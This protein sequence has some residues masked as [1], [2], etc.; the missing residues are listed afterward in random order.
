MGD[1][2][3][4][5]IRPNLSKTAGD[6]RSH[7][8][9][10]DTPIFSDTLQEVTARRALVASADLM[11]V[12][13]LVVEAQR[14]LSASSEPLARARLHHALGALLAARFD[15]WDEALIH[16][17]LAHELQPEELGY[18]RALRHIY[19]YLQ[20][21]TEVLRLIDVE[22]AVSDEPERRLNL[23][24]EKGTI[25]AD[26]L[27]CQDRARECYEEAL[28]IGPGHWP[29][30]T[31]LRWIYVKRGEHAAL[32]EICH[33]AIAASSSR[34]R[35]S[36]LYQLV[37]ELQADVLS[38][39]S[40]AMEN[41]GLAHVEDP[42]NATARL[43]L[44]QIYTQHER[45]RDLVDVLVTA[46]DLADD[47]A[48]R[49]DRY[50]RAA[51][52]CRDKLQEP[53]RA[54]DL[55][56]TAVFALGV[57]SV[58]LGELA[59]LLEESGRH[60]DLIA[61]Y[62]HCLQRVDGSI[63]GELHRALGRLHEELGDVDQAVRHLGH[64]LEYDIPDALPRLERV[65]RL[66]G[67]WEAWV[68]VALELALQHE[69]AARG[70]RIGAVAAVV[71]RELADSGRA[72]ALYG[73]AIALDEGYVEGR[74]Q[75]RSLL[76]RDGDFEGVL[77]L[78]EERLAAEEGDG[79]RASL[80]FEMGCVAEYGLAEPERAARYHQ[81]AKEGSTQG[82]AEQAHRRN[83][84]ALGEVAE[85]FELTQACAK[86]PGREIQQ[87]ALMRAGAALLAR[88]LQRGAEAE[89]H[90]GRVL[91]QY[92]QDEVASLGLVF[93]LEERG[94]WSELA[95]ELQR[96]LTVVPE[97]RAQLA[98]HERLA[99]LCFRQLTRP[100]AALGH[101]REAL[102]LD[103]HREDLFSSMLTLCRREGEWDELV[104]AVS[105]R[106]E[107][108]SNSY[109]R[110][111]LLQLLGETYQER[112][113]DQISA[114][115]ALKDAVE[116]NAKG[117]SA[118]EMLLELLA[119]RAEH[120]AMLELLERSMQDAYSPTAQLD[121]LKQLARLQAKLG[122]V[123]KAM[124]SYGGALALAPAD[125]ESL[126]ALL[127]LHAEV[128][129]HVGLVDAWR[130]LASF[131][132]DAVDS[133]R[134]FGEA[135]RWSEAYLALERDVA[136]I[137]RQ[138]LESNPDDEVALLALERIA[139][140]RRD[141]VLADDICERLFER[142]SEPIR[143]TELSFRLCAAKEASGDF[144]AAASTLEDVARTDPQWLV[145]H[146]LRRLYEVQGD[147]EAVAR[148]LEREAHTSVDQVRTR[149]ALHAAAELHYEQLNAPEQALELLRGV[150]QED[151]HHGEAAHLLEQILVQRGD[152]DA[153]VTAL[154]E[155]V[156]VMRCKGL[157]AGG[158]GQAQAQITLLARMAW[159]QREHLGRPEAAIATL[160]QVLEVEPHHLPT[161]QTLAELCS[162]AAHWREAVE[163]YSTLVG[164]S[165]D[166]DLLLR[167][168]VALG[169]IF[170]DKLSER[171]LAISSYQNVLAIEPQQ[172][173][174][175]GR[176]A[177]LFTQRQEWESAAEMVQR[178]LEG[179]Q[180]PNEKAAHLVA[181]ADIFERGYRDLEAA[182]L[183]YQSALDLDPA[184]AEVV[185]CLVSL[186]SRLGQWERACEA[187]RVYLASLPEPRQ[188][189]GLPR[190]MILAKILHG[191]LR[192]P[193]EALEQ[194]RAV[195][196]I[197]PTHMES[198]LRMGEILAEEGRS[199]E[200]VV[201][202]REILEVDP[203]NAEALQ[204]LCALWS[205]VGAGEQAYAAAAALVTTGAA[206]EQEQRI[207][208]EGRVDG[209]R[210]PSAPLDPSTFATTLVHPGE[211]HTGRAILSALAEVAPKIFPADLSAWQI[212]KAD[213]LS[214][215]SDDPVI[216]TSRQ[217]C[218]VLG[219]EQE[220]DV[221]VSHTRLREMDL[222]LTDPPALVVGGGVMSSFSSREVR[223]GIAKLLCYLRNRTVAAY[224]LDTTGLK[225]L[226]AAARRVVEPTCDLPR[227]VE[228]GE[229]M[230]QAEAI[231][232]AL[233]RRGRH[234]LEEATLAFTEARLPSYAEWQVGLNLTALR[235]ALWLVNDIDTALRHLRGLSPDLV[236]ANSNDTFVHNAKQHRAA[237]EL[238]R[239]W[240]SEDYLRAKH[241]S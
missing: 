158:G 163:V 56:E 7:T 213:R 241:A 195:S 51:R 122:M 2:D 117:A 160:R 62:L 141:I 222:L 29:L 113:D 106:L 234:Q 197:D 204:A 36:R 35:R 13:E 217:V 57:E 208:K 240:L 30:F 102:A 103:P 54:A 101:Y 232:R 201:Q 119:A 185:D 121:L 85:L 64:A 181:L 61:I 191:T 45:W 23:L 9:V 203:L 154:G 228:P 11:V 171:K 109:E 73:Q 133:A 18:T 63:R 42:Q 140:E 94:G 84:A 6:G 58:A 83:L 193:K 224:R 105:R 233:S 209:V 55:L 239:F 28:G 205:R 221:Y 196:E 65:L 41:L 19:R 136:L 10:S 25:F 46:G 170:Q 162:A 89:E 189:E 8:I 155:R 114:I 50:L 215:R 110:S 26:R 5:E 147:W 138:A 142:A 179:D 44:Q 237:A 235:A 59:D 159:I 164:L 31:Q 48:Q 236:K 115:D 127:L 53:A 131:S 60:A 86:A 207:F 21:W 71:E 202:L 146:A 180:E 52:I 157:P 100:E 33:K 238:M 169:R 153:L 199:D 39:P 161:L 37:G 168:H 229:V 125:F 40:T 176:L 167:A 68:D 111:S 210:A 95:E 132:A 49:G 190:R 227:G 139:V 81:R 166:P 91:A 198:R 67:R 97:G 130:Q 4:Q 137:Y 123:D 96:R 135:A 186:F 104:S 20:N 82:A 120:A 124:A 24:L 156:S 219:L 70:A 216:L 223:F 173:D 192:R 17:Q 90:Y 77:K 47:E 22:L 152:W 129:D 112:L 183:R 108:V 87:R 107:L 174:A 88:D 78:L 220:V 27:A 178:L 230:L 16:H 93:L 214:P 99:E 144:A 212:G 134:I 116:A 66:A 206:R 200:A 187:T 175:L 43:R 3:T 145:F 143:R 118:K 72:I 79:E 128:G 194:Y 126:D 218:E 151:P 32:V 98:I 12:R 150:L 225:T 231:H 226:V 148:T 75:L 15:D 38:D 74:E 76:T 69:G 80:L 149:V 165:D 1:T 34:H 172:R 184:N 188:R 182:A 92:P 14:E 211:H 177:E